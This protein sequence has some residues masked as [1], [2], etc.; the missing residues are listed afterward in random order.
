MVAEAKRLGEEGGGRWPKRRPGRGGEGAQ[1]LSIAAKKRKEQA[2]LDAD[3]VTAARV[4][5]ECAA[6]LRTE[7]AKKARG[8]AEP[9]MRESEANAR[10][11][12]VE[13]VRNDPRSN[14]PQAATR[15]IGAGVSGDVRGAVRARRRSWRSASRAAR[16]I[17]TQ[18]PRYGG[19]SGGFR[20]SGGGFGSRGAATVAA[21]AGATAA[22]E[23]AT[24]AIAAG[25]AAH[26]TA[27]ATAEG[28]TATGEATVAVTG[29]RT[30]AATAAVMEAATGAAA[31]AATAAAASARRERGG[32]FGARDRGPPAGGAIE[33]CR[34]REGISPTSRRHR[35]SADIAESPEMDKEDARRSSPTSMRRARS[36]PRR[37]W[38]AARHRWGEDLGLNVAVLAPL[39]RFSTPLNA[40]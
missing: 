30:A 37:T 2:A 15:M 38:P 6:F 29:A 21:T 8:S 1:R 26:P 12:A 22:T 13:S 40:H 27:G 35:P 5:R 24:A 36:P 18:I 19:G 10:G 32:S 25:T 11:A 20:G 3:A 17:S 33:A 9:S 7:E 31:A 16:T 34:R 4:A 39:P 28:P 14:A 23:A